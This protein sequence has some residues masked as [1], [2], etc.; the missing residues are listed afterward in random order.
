MVTMYQA[1]LTVKEFHVVGDITAYLRSHG[2]LS[3]GTSA[4][5]HG[6]NVLAVNNKVI[7]LEASCVRVEEDAR[8]LCGGKLADEV[9]DFFLYLFRDN[10]LIRSRLF[11]ELWQVW[12]CLWYF[13]RIHL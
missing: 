5:V 8:P 1:G 12:N 3:V 11:Y 4:K 7:S 9:S 10:K 2:E 6:I 13:F